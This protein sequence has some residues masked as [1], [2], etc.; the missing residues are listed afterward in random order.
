MLSVWGGG[1]RVKGIT[2]DAVESTPL[3]AHRFALSVFRF[4]C[5]E[6]TEIFCGARDD[7]CEEEDFDTA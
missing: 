1:C 5:T 3:V 6:L 2:H 7:V 4:A